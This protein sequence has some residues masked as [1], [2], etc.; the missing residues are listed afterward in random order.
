MLEAKG[1]PQSMAAGRD[2]RG[3][4]IPFHLLLDGVDRQRPVGLFLVPEHLLA[5]P[6]AWAL[7]QAFSP[8]CPRIGRQLHATSFAPLALCN[9][10]GV[11]RP[12]EIT[13]LQR[14]HF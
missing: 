10:Q 12:V 14:G 1:L 4:G 6:A 2:P 3:L 13:P 5:W 11:R 7:L 9:D 8:A